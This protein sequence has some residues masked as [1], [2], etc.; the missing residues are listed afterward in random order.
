[1]KPSRLRAGAAF[2]ID[3]DDADLE[4]SVRAGLE[5]VEQGLRV[6]VRSDQ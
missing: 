1:M 2:G 4:A 6:A 3:F 5:A